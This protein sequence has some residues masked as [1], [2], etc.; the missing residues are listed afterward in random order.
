[1]GSGE[2]GVGARKLRSHSHSPF[3][4]PH[5]LFVSPAV[6]KTNYRKN[7][8]ERGDGRAQALRCFCEPAFASSR[9]T[10]RKTISARSSPVRKA[11]LPR[12]ITAAGSL[13]VK[14][15]P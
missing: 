13:I 11:F 8:S 9:S 10:L 4:T 14:S 6:H 5:S 3:P 12:A 1:M 15:D 2:W 7:L